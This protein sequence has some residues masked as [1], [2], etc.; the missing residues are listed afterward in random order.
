M[1]MRWNC[2]I[3][4]NNSETNQS[5]FSVLFQFYFT[6]ESV[7]NKTETNLFYFSF[8]SVLLPRCM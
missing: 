5:C 7:W 1:I 2:R 3:N 6:C 8:I 4:W